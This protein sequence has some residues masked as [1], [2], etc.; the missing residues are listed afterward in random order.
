MPRR[1][2]A[3]AAGAVALLVAAP[4]LAYAAK[5]AKPIVVVGKGL[6]DGVIEV[7]DRRT[8]ERQDV[9]VASAASDIAALLA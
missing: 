7:K 1:R 6:A 8:D 5:P 3:L 4:T 2:L 9:P